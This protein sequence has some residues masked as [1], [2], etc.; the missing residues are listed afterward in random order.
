MTEPGHELKTSNSPKPIDFA[1]L[2]E[3]GVQMIWW[4]CYIQGRT[5]FLLWFMWHSHPLYF[6]HAN[7]DFANMKT[8]VNHNMKKSNQCTFILAK[9]ND[10]RLLISFYASGPLSA[11]LPTTTCLRRLPSVDCIPWFLTGFSQGKAK[12][13]TE[14]GC[15]FPSVPCLS[16]HSLFWSDPNWYKQHQVNS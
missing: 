15:Y 12:Q 8:L 13:K 11:P 4:F 6:G 5:F 3:N 10:P 16:G 2:N 9:E 14:I 1:S 7:L